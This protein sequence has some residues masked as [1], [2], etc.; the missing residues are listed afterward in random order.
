MENS[1]VQLN[2]AI[3]YGINCRGRTECLRLMFVLSGRK[4]VDRRITLV[5]WKEIKIKENFPSNAMLPVLKLAMESQPIIG[6]IEIGRYLATNLGFYGSSQDEKL[7]IDQIIDDLEKLHVA[8][9]PVIRTTLTK[10][11]DKRREYWQIFKENYLTDYL[12]KFEAKL[13]QRIF[14]VGNK[15]SWADMAVADV[16]SAFTTCFDTF[17]LNS[18]PTLKAHALRIEGLPNIRT[19]VAQRPHTSF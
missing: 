17:L 2:G 11:F 13:G 18:Y 6:A 14:F 5:E 9:A 1:S 7:E 19:Y 16:L 15:I 3:L 4:F 12:K 10:N 8:V